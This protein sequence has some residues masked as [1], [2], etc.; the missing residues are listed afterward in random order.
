MQFSAITDKRQTV[1]IMT[2]VKHSDKIC[3]EAVFNAF[4]TSSMHGYD[5]CFK[6]KKRE[7]K[8][9][10]YQGLTMAT[11]TLHR[12]KTRNEPAT[13]K[14]SVKKKQQQTFVDPG[15][16]PVVQTFFIG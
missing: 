6:L 5:G 9:K 10:R 8:T 2:T 14:K 3:K 7:K 4:L 11:T 16:I 13:H 12:K 15:Y 1:E